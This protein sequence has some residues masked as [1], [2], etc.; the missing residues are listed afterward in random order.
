VEVA[1]EGP[2]AVYEG[3]LVAELLRRAGAAL[4]AELRG[5]AL[6]TYVLARAADGYQVVF[7]IGELDPAL[8]ANEI[9][10]ADTVDG[11]PLPDTQGPFRLVA[12]R[13]RRGVRSVR[14]LERLELVRLRN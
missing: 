4:G 9:I 14:L 8:T 10:V 5:N 13:D 2:A 7:S 6:A 3:V 12:P 1:R 11:A